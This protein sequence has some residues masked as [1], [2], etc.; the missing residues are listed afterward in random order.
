LA[1]LPPI[2]YDKIVKKRGKRREGK[3]GKREGE[4]EEREEGK[5]GEKGEH[6]TAGGGGV[7]F[8]WFS[9]RLLIGYGAVARFKEDK[10]IDEKHRI[11]DAQTRNI[12]EV[13]KLSR[14][15]CKNVWPKLCLKGRS[16]VPAPYVPGP[17]RNLRHGT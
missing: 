10:D 12:W 2:N 14:K 5:W 7:S 3:E 4:R 11:I 17:C 8:G 15:I 16:A 13:Q 6:L 9:I 1:W